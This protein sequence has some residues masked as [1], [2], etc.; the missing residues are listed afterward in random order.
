MPTATEQG[1][2]GVEVNAWYGVFAPAAT[3]AATVARL[4]REINEIIKLP[5]VREK[6]MGAG[7][8]ALGGSPQV[9]ADFMK[10]DNERYGTL[11][12]ELNIKAD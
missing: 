10:A 5:D 6:L 8:E 2:T 1:V 7:V 3:P 12:R 9:L 11:A 4:N